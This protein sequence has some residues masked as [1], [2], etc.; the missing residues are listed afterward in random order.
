[1]LELSRSSYYYRPKM[2][3]KLRGRPTSTS[4]LK[5][6][7]TW[8]INEQ[9]IIDIIEIRSEEFV[10]YG[11]RK[12][13]YALKQDYDYVIN[14]KKVYRLMTENKLL[15]LNISVKRS[16]RL[17]VTELVP[18]AEHYFSYLEFDIKYFWVSGC[19]RN[20]LILTVIDVHSRWVLGQYIG[21]QISQF[22]VINLFDKIFKRHT[23]PEKIYV[24]N[25]NGSQMEAEK[26]QI[27]F[28]NK[29]VIQEFTK[30]ATPEQNAHIESYHS[31]MEKVI[32]SKYEF[33]NLDEV[34]ETFDRWILFY[35]FRRIHSGIDYLSPYKY[36]LR[37]GIN[38]KLDQSLLEALVFSPTNIVKYFNKIVQYL[39][40]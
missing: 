25:D 33:D 6:N 18:K 7:N 5:T 27:Y 16:K 36:L 4:T 24:R 22:D 32:C 35:N 20:V 29:G 31:I 9:V 37:K 30:P 15:N 34:K 1:M 40:G 38:L 17:W 28:R 23:L 39:G 21:W 12:M 3:S 10:D 19:K 8:V 11:Y 2:D 14:E 26:V 13:T